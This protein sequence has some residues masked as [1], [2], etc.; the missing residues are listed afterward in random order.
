MV[1]VHGRSKDSGIGECEF[2]YKVAEVG[3]AVAFSDTQVFRA[4]LAFSVQI[5]LVVEAGAFHDESVLFPMC[6]RVSEPGRLGVNRQFPAIRENLT[7]D[8]EFFEQC[9]DDSRGLVILMGSGITWFE[10]LSAR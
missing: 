1:A 10:T 8:G 5:R 2:D 6:D 9:Q 3:P 4:R 7:E